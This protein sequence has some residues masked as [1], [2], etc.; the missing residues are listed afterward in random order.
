VADVT[1]IQVAGNDTKKYTGLQYAGIEFANPVING[2]S[3]EYFHI[4][5][6]TTDAVPVKVKLVDFGA[7][8]SYDGG[9][10][11]VSIEYELSPAPTP[12][13]WTGY[14]IPLSSFTGL[15]TKAHLAQMV[16]IGTGTLYIDNVYLFNSSVLPVKITGFKVIPDHNTAILQWSTVSEQNN[17]GFSI[18]RSANTT[19]WNEIQFVK[20]NNGTASRN[21]SVTDSRPLNGINYYRLKQVDMNGV[22]TYSPVLS[23]KFNDNGTAIFFSPNPAKG[24]LNISI[25]KIGNNNTS[26]SLVNASGQKVLSMMLK[27]ETEKSQVKMDI[28]KLPVGVY[29]VV[30]NDGHSVQ[31]QKLV[32]E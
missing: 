11:K 13:S 16:L 30:L 31:S 2:T 8:G 22:I 28:S 7:N 9:D 1:D 23:A 29:M 14:D 26:L 10:D 6:Y 4:D 19:S 24:S 25:K 27:K 3:M 17:S 18:E 12:A 15:D 20:A 32:I 21:Y 5:V